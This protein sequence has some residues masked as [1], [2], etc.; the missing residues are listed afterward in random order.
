MTH[1][2]IKFR[3]S[4]V[5]ILLNIQSGDLW[6]EFNFFFAIDDREIFSRS[7][8]FP[9]ILLLQLS[10]LFCMHLI[11]CVVGLL[12]VKI[13]FKSRYSLL[14]FAIHLC[15][16]T[17]L[18][19]FKEALKAEPFLLRCTLV[20]RAVLFNYSLAHV[21]HVFSWLKNKNSNNF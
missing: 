18:M 7:L 16:T 5:K 1:F 20:L 13:L 8:Q 21:I 4:R 10:S 2:I 19:S 6:A 9:F 11:V 3:K 12:S 14:N 17:R 15:G